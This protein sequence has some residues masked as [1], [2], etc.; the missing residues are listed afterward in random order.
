MRWGR[1]VSSPSSSPCVL[2]C[3]PLD[4]AQLRGDRP[5]ERRLAR[6]DLEDGDRAE[7]RVTVLVDL[8]VAEDPVGDVGVEDLLRNLGAV[9]LARTLDRVE[10]HVGRLC[11]IDRVRVRSRPLLRGEAVDELLA[12][13]GQLID[14]D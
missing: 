1:T 9:E 11:G 14:R 10:Q 7:G 3:L 6:L 12:F 5:D 13:A 4:E 8:E 2:V